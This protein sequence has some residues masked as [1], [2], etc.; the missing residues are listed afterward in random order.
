MAIGHDLRT[1]ITR[2]KLRSEFI[3]DKH[4]QKKFISDLDELE[5]MIDATTAFGRDNTHHEPVINLDLTSLIETLIHEL[6]ETHPDKIDQIRLHHPLPNYT[7]KA[8]PIN[9]KE[10]YKT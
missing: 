8:R 7:I 3:N 2:L 4:L 6:Q 1:P 5:K 9:L 10:P